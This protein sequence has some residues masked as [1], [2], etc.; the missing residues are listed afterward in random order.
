M[1]FCNKVTKFIKRERETK[2]NKTETINKGRQ[3]GYEARQG[4]E[5]QQNGDKLDKKKQEIKIG[6]N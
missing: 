3:I 2:L 1:K 5:A 6:K 4:D